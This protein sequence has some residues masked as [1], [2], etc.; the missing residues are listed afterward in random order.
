MTPR[1]CDACLTESPVGAQRQ[2]VHPAEPGG[3]VVSER[4]RVVYDPAVAEKPF[5]LLVEF[6]ALATRR[7]ELYL[8]HSKARLLREDI[9][10][11]EQED[12]ERRTCTNNRHHLDP[13]PVETLGSGG[14][15]KRCRYCPAEVVEEPDGTDIEV[16]G[17]SD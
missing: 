9:A 4:P 17:S 3:W 13:E 14:V 8:S 15:V 11:A 6:G 1:P 16:S 10:R 2:H 12:V 7:V 5:V